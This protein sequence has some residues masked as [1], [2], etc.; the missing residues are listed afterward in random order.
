MA[1]LKGGESMPQQSSLPLFLDFATVY[2]CAIKPFKGLPQNRSVCVLLLD[3]VADGSLPLTDAT[4]SNYVTGKRAIPDNYRTAFANINDIRIK[5][6]FKNLRIY[7]LQIPADALRQLIDHVQLPEAT[8]NK[9][10]KSYQTSTATSAPEQ[11]LA[12][13]FRYSADTKGSHLL[14]PQD[15]ALIAAIASPNTTNHSS[16][17]RSEEDNLNLGSGFSEED[18]LW[19]E[20]YIPPALRATNKYITNNSFFKTPVTINQQSLTL[21]LDFLP[22]LFLLKPVLREVQVTTFTY[23]QFLDCTGISLTTGNLQSGTL[24]YL[25]IAGPIDGVVNAIQNLNFKDACSVV[26]LMKGPMTSENANQL[27]R[28]IKDASFPTIK[29]LRSL[30]FDNQL[31]D[32]EVVLIINV[33]S[34]QAKKMRDDFAAQDGDVRIYEQK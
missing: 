5:E 16:F 27:E 33:D 14:S 3:K 13:V 4:C 17:E 24:Q 12:E 18:L 31:S 28:A 9:L 26:L 7:N 32:V 8:Y 29:L 6:K 23:D 10:I 34:E 20:D 11:F 22:L 15:L 2:Q 25:K 21:P 19:M 1:P 30:I